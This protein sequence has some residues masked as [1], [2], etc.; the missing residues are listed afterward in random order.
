MSGACATD[1][2]VLACKSYNPVKS[3]VPNEQREAEIRLKLP[4]SVHWLSC[5]ISS[6]FATGIQ[7]LD[8]IICIYIYEVEEVFP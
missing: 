7:I 1:H 8:H 2:K 6:A 4:A 3:R 5:G